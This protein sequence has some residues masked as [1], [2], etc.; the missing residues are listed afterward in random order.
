[1]IEA[2]LRTDM[3]KVKKQGK[4]EGERDIRVLESSLGREEEETEVEN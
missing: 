3:L 1:M 2:L 4:K